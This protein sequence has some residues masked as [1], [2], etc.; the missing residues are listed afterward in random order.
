MPNDNLDRRTFNEFVTFVGAG[1]DR[2]SFH[3]FVRVEADAQGDLPYVM[4]W[5]YWNAFTAAQ[6]ARDEQDTTSDTLAARHW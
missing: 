3:R 4:W 2:E 5:L 1:K 6:D